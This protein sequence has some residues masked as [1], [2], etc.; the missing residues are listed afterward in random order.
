M[1]WDLKLPQMAVFPPPGADG[2]TAPLGPF[3]STGLQLPTRRACVGGARGGGT[4]G[5]NASGS[6]AQPGLLR[7]CAR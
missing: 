2:P 6:G 5:G 3:L 4:G 7:C 1:L